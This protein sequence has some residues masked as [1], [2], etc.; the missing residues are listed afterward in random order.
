MFITKRDIYDARFKYSD[1]V[2]D[3]IEEGRWIWPTE[4][5]KKHKDFPRWK[6][7]ED[8]LIMIVKD[9]IKWKL[10]SLKVKKSIAVTKVFEEWG[11]CNESAGG[12][13][14]DKN[15]EES[16]ALLKD[17]AFY[18]NESWNDL[19]DFAKPVKAIF[20]PQDVPS[21]SDRRLIELENQVKGLME[22]HLAPNPPV[23]VNKIASTCEICSGPHNTQYCMKNPEQ[24]FVDYTSSHSN[25]VGEK[26]LS[27]LGTQLMQQQQ[28]EVINKFN[29]L[30]KV[31]SEKFNNPP[32][33]DVAKGPTPRINGVYHA[34][35]E[36]GA[37][38]N[39]GIKSPSKLLS[40]KYQSQSSLGE[41]NRSSSSPSRVYFVNTITVIRKEDKSREAGTKESIA[42]EDESRDIKW[43]DP[44]DRMCGETKEEEEGVEEE[45]EESEDETEEEEEDDLEYFDTFP[46]IEELGYHEWLLKDPRP[47]WVSA[48]VKTGNLNNIK[49]SCMVGHFLKEQAY[50]DLDS[51]INVMSRLNYYWIMSE[52][53]K[54]RR[55]PSNPKKISNFVGRVKGLKVFV[56]SFTYEC[57]FVMLKDTTSVIDHYLG[58]MVLGKP[59]VKETRLRQNNPFLENDKKIPSLGVLD[60]EALGG[61]IGDL[62]SIWEETRQDCNFTRSGFKDARTVPGDGVAI[63]S[64]AVRTYK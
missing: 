20:L 4:C 48:K 6:R 32:A 25:E 17:L 23:Q 38:P 40:P 37:P 34:H 39:K 61:N 5:E 30:W 55:K 26:S 31:I 47:P 58:G 43:N 13:L 54:S 10:A 12:K 9:E 51:P 11:V 19:R 44:D 46:T 22:A 21:T 63:P 64:D 35:H 49:I 16:W 18:D 52:G 33:R 7:D 29:T 28:D 53:L 59:F 60:E 56:G 8:T 62:D 45:S 36:N 42:A 24:A 50:I 2:A 1:K 14:R 57:D 3:L 41:Q 15:I 27:S